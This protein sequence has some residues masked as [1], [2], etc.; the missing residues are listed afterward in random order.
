M[1]WPRSIHT[2]MALSLIG[3]GCHDRQPVE[4]ASPPSTR[5]VSQAPTE[6]R[7]DQFGFR[8]TYPQ[9]WQPRPS[10]DFVLEFVPIDPPS[11]DAGRSISIDVPKLPPHL[12][13]MIRIPLIQN[14]L[15]D[16]VKKKFRDVQIVES[17]DVDF[18]DAKARRLR[19][20]WTGN[21]QPF[22]Q[23][24]LMLIHHDRVYIIRGT[25]PAT[26]FAATNVSFEQIV[27]SLSSLKW[28]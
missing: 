18:P 23:E 16:D 26:N 11:A 20:R 27:S 28:L 25:S 17:R 4:V 8:V 22:E 12:P 19:L 9:G 5:P 24:V 14:G 1:A 13:G 15:V 7:S 3:F 6:F 10:E 2:F 21:G